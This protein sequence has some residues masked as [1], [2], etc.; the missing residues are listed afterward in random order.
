MEQIN[1][2]IVD[3]ASLM[4]KIL[5]R[6]LSEDPQINVVGYAKNGFECL[7]KIEKYRPDVVSLDIDMPLMDGLTT[8]KHIMI[9]KP[10]P[11]VVVSSMTQTGYVTFEALRLGVVDFI[12]KPSGSISLD[13]GTQETI[14][15]NRIKLSASIKIENVRRVWFKNRNSEADNGQEVSAPTKIIG[16][17]T[18]LG[19]PNTIIRIVSSLATNFSG[20]ILAMQEIDLQILPAFCAYFDEIAPIRVLPAENDIPLSSGTCYLISNRCD[21]RIEENRKGEKILKLTKSIKN[22]ISTMFGSIASN[23]G[24]NSMG[25]LLTGTGTDGVRGLEE[26]KKAG[27]QTVAQDVECCVFPNLTHSA[28]EKG[29]VQ[30]ILPDKDISRMLMD[31]TN[32]EL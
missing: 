10:T 25:I 4:Q 18:S 17:G 28:I 16:I 19:G 5:G 30:Y 29:V 8:I 12:P 20:T 21:V 14:L 6:I 24:E 15:K 31:W 9:E 7:E 13:M 32:K 1:V 23:F 3:D 11:T 27:G 22:P 2:L 26:I